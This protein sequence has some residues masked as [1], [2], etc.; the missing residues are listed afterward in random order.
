MVLSHKNFNLNKINGFSLLELIIVI[1]LIGIMSIS[2]GKLTTNTIIGYIDAKDRNRLSQSAKW[3]TEKISREI[4]EALPQSIRTG[5]S[6]DFHCVEFL[7]I[8]NAS[9]YLALENSGTITSITAVDN[10]YD[11]ASSMANLVAIMPIN[12]NLVYN[13]N[14][15]LASILS[16]SPSI[17]EPFQTVINLSTATNF[18]NRSPQNRFYLLTNPVS[19]CLN[20]SNGQF[21]KYKNYGLSSSQDFPPT[22]GEILAE[23]F[24]VNGPVFNYQSGSLSRSGILQ[25][26]FHTQNRKRSLSSTEEVIDIFHEVHI[27][28]VP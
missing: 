15:V 2:F 17:T 18:T 1:I 25:L 10:N 4:R 19:F 21:L 5:S 14:G 28:N 23:N 26:N 8:V 12:T 24:F 13:F 11:I 20:N 3:L 27:R 16:I 9:S 7:P 22:G 6:S